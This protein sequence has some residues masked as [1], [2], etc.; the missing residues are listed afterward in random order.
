[1]SANDTPALEGTPA[2]LIVNC[3]SGTIFTI[4][5]DT[6]ENGANCYNMITVDGSTIYKTLWFRLYTAIGG[7]RDTHY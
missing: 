5:V 2:P 3:G 1:M 7:E 6:N 4:K